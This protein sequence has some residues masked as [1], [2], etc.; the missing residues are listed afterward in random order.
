MQWN[1]YNIANFRGTGLVE[2]FPCIVV[3]SLAVNILYSC[4]V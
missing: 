1:L 4:S 3:Y 2:N